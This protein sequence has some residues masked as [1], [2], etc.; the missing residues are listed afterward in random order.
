MF[1]NISN[2]TFHTASVIFHDSKLPQPESYPPTSMSFARA[3]VPA[4]TDHGVI[5][6]SFWTFEIDHG[7]PVTQLVFVLREA[8]TRLFQQ[9]R[10]CSLEG[11]REREDPYVVDW[12]DWGPKT[13]RWFVAPR[14]GQWHC[15]VHGYRFVTLVTRLEA[16]I[17]I[18]PSFDVEDPQSDS[19]A[20]VHLH[21]L[22]FDFN[23]YSLRRHQYSPSLPTHGN[24]N[25]N[26]VVIAPSDMTSHDLE[27][28]FQED[29]I[30]RLGYRVTLMDE[31]AD[32]AGLAACEDNIICFQ[33]RLSQ[34][35]RRER[36]N[37]NILNLDG[38]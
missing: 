4:Q 33:V 36:I 14:L 27:G 6:M 16:S 23:P 34:H 10:E 24:D 38:K 17:Y 11:E 25:G 31:P 32:C 28:R 21:P 20:V 13:S 12:A 7:E 9:E 19:D 2:G 22:V 18:S 3:T 37:K 5:A 8:L 29:V 26:N 1:P 15:S 35:T 30:G